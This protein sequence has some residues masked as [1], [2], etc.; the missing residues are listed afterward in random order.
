MWRQIV[1]KNPNL[2]QEF[3]WFFQNPQTNASIV[4]FLYSLGLS[5]L[6]DHVQL[7]LVILKIFKDEDI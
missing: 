3:A 7:K 5:N 1:H 2:F 4:A 6:P